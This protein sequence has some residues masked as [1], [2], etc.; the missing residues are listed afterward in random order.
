MASTNFIIGK[1]I[2]LGFI[3]FVVVCSFIVMGSSLG[4]ISD[5]K[6]DPKAK[7]QKGWEAELNGNKAA[8]IIVILFGDIIQILG[9]LGKVL[10]V[11]VL[12]CG[13]KSF[14]WHCHILL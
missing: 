9:F 3:G 10:R 5:L 11:F 1:F 12:F 13:V 4:K 8:I 7:D 6:P 14:G 2:L